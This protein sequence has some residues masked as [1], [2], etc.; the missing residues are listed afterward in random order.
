MKRIYGQWLPQVS[1]LKKQCIAERNC[2]YRILNFIGRSAKN[3]SVYVILNL[4]LVLVRPHFGLWRLVLVY[5]KIHIILL[6]SVVQRTTM[7]A[8][9]RNFPSET[10]L[11]LL[12]K[13]V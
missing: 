5:Y 11:K 1:A 3:G 2:V 13:R 9:I 8:G 6:E 4:C 10:R 7:I 12:N